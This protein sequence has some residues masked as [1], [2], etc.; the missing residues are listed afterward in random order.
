MTMPPLTPLS[1]SIAFGGARIDRADHVRADPG[2]I[3]AL[4]AGGAACC[5]WTG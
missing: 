1:S 3:E 4:R 5:G 2:A